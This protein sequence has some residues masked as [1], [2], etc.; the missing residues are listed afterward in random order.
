MPIDYAN[1]PMTLEHRDAV[2][3]AASPRPWRVAEETRD[4]YERHGTFAHVEDA[5]GRCVCVT[6]SAKCDEDAEL[7]VYAVNTLKSMQPPNWV[8]TDEERNR[9]V[10]ECP[11]EYI[12]ELEWEL[13]YAIRSDEKAGEACHH[14]HE[15]FMAAREKRERFRDLVR[16]FAEYAETFHALGEQ[17]KQLVAE[18]REALGEDAR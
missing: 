1:I 7:I 18:A 2:T 8:L 5:N 4:V 6:N 12:K 15:L 16:R 13:Q 14:W 11:E 9:R 3:A 10:A 17:G